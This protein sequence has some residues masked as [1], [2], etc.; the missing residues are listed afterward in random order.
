MKKR[1]SGVLACAGFAALLCGAS[2]ASAQTL[3]AA[4]SFAVLGGTAVTANGSGGHINGDVGIAPAAASAITGIPAN[5][6]VTPPFVNQGNNAVAIAA[7]AATLTL[8]NALFGM[9]GATV[10][11]PGLNGQTRG[12]GT[13]SSGD[14][15]L[16]SGTPLTLSGAGQY[17]FKVN[18]ITTDVGSS[19]NLVGVDPCMVFWQV[20]TI[21]A[22]NGTTF[23][24]NIVA[25]TGVHLV[26]ANSSL[27]GRALVEAGGDVTMNGGT[28]GGCSVLGQGVSPFLAVPTLTRTG[29]L[30][31]GT[32][33]T[34]MTDTKTLSGGLGSAAPTGTIIFTL[35]SDASCTNLVFTSS[36]VTV[37]GNGSFTSPPFT[38]TVP[39]TFHWIATYSGDANN[40]PTATACG[41][42]T[43]IVIVSG[44]V[45]PPGF[46]GIP[47]LSG[48]G[49][50]TLTVL[51]GLASIYRLRR[52]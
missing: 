42:T 24:G 32:V 3:G 2:P 50:I 26:T 6:T 14:V 11:L 45:I 39:G 21:A 48:W 37:T 27:L 28:V 8:Y 40:A 7:R 51:I 22:L 38:P 18:S 19:V 20:N 33:G 29:S 15:T 1:S 23:P 16:T 12:P 34:P 47:T 35:F 30:P 36:A 41:D 31:N 17:I 9:G 46:A 13:Y 44:S 4:Q 10:I 25:G 52:I 43:E 49:L 5:A